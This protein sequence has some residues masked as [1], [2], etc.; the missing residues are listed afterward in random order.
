MTYSQN[1]RSI[2]TRRYF[3]GLAGLTAGGAAFVTGY[4]ALFNQSGV[5]AKKSGQHLPEPELLRVQR[6][7]PDFVEAEIVAS[8]ASVVLAGIRVQP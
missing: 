2:L 1:Q 3:L 7:E 4:H 6:L 8:H 5:R